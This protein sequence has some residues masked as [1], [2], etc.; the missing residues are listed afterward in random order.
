M[1][2]QRL[3]AVVSIGGS[4]YKITTEDIILVRN[5]FYPTVGDRIRL[6]KVSRLAVTENLIESLTIITT[7]KLKKKGAFSWRKGFHDSRKT[8]G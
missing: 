5:Q 7:N 1:L 6:E 8:I 2:N 4:Q 3:F